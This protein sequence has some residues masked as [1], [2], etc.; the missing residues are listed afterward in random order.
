[1][2]IP[3]IA[4]ALLL[5]TGAALAAQRPV[6]EP[7]PR[8]RGP[9]TVTASVTGP[10]EI[11][12]T[13]AE[14]PGA[15]HYDLGFHSPP[16]GWRR[17]E[18]VPGS[19]TQYVHTGRDLTRTHQ[20]SI[21]VAVGDA[22]SLPVRS[23]IVAAHAAVDSTPPVTAPVT[24]P[25]ATITVTAPARC[26]QDHTDPARMFCSSERRDFTPLHSGDITLTATCPDGYQVLSGGHSTLLWGSS[27]LRAS[28]PDAVS[29]WW[30]VWVQAR[31]DPSRPQMSFA[32]A[33]AICVRRAP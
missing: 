2:R 8:P 21:V 24:T 6:R 14:V 18:R 10:G 29:R 13:W 11:T 26:V 27:E 31:R 3:L 20:Y 1:M 17:V 33:H 16:D 5:T 7:T 25:A 15:T 23:N 12:V 30:Y 32:Q 9:A 19:A 28:Y 22:A 4:A